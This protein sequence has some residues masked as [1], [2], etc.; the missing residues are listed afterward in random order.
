MEIGTKYKSPFNLTAGMSPINKPMT[1]ALLKP[2]NF[3][4][5]CSSWIK[6]KHNRVSSETTPSF[7]A[8]RKKVAPL[9]IVS[10]QIPARIPSAL[11]SKTLVK[12]IEPRPMENMKWRN[13]LTFKDRK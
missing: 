8:T 7:F 11:F 12:N 13:W 4:A 5:I 3:G 10:K 1:A 2:L 6:T 9:L